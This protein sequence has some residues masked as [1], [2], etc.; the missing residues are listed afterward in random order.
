MNEKAVDALV[1]VMGQCRE[2]LLQ[3][4]GEVDDHMGVSP[5]MVTWATVGDAQR[6]Q[7]S[8][9][10]I[11]DW[12]G[13]RGVKQPPVVDRMR[14]MLQ[15]ISETPGAEYALESVSISKLYPAMTEI[16]ATMAGVEEVLREALE[17][18]EQMEV[19]NDK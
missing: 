14:L 4:E 13:A 6:L 9:A 10:E 15:R 5:E 12:L 3:I 11:V 19:T 1:G 7:H 18:M 8:L 2:H 16:D 17:V